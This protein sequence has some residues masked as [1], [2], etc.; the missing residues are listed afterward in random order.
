[1]PIW[2]DGFRI[3]RLHVVFGLALYGF[4]LIGTTFEHH[5]LACHQKSPTH[6]SSCVANPMASRVEAG[7]APAST[8]LPVSGRLD[9]PAV[10]EIET[11]L[12]A[13]LTGRSPP[14]SLRHASNFV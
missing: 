2:Q 3:R 10:I 11:L 7:G 14:A 13:R 6:C 1:M 5:D 9:T 12:P 4:V 8:Q